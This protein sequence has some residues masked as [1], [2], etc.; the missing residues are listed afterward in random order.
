MKVLED[1]A[2]RTIL[3][4]EAAHEYFLGKVKLLSVTKFVGSFFPE[5]DREAVAEKYA[6]KHN[7]N[8]RD[9]LE[10]WDK[11]QRAAS[12]KGHNLHAYA[13]ALVTDTDSEWIDRYVD[14]YKKINMALK[15]IKSKFKVLGAEVIVASPALGLA[16]TIDLL[17]WDEATSDVLIFDWK[18]SKNISKENVWE[19]AYPP[20]EHLDDCNFNHY[21]LQLNTYE[22][23]CREENYFPTAVNYRKA[24]IDIESRSTPIFMKVDDLQ[25]EVDHMIRWI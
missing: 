3:F 22:R 7:L 11:D 10:T 17:C 19:T 8:V 18:S 21:S 20:I 14:G 9:V 4:E 23:I 1:R 15:Q 2:G 6:M 12:D 5:F 16:G 25:T 13:Y 24:L